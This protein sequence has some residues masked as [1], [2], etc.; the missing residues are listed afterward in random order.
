MA[1]LNCRIA[2]LIV[3]ICMTSASSPAPADAATAFDAAKSAILAKLKD[4]ES[5]KFGDMWVRGRD[6]C[7]TVNAK[8]QFGGYEGPK[9]FLFSQDLGRGFIDDG[10]SVSTDP[11][12]SI[13]R[14]HAQH[15][16]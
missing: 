6:I 4:P 16:R 11:L 1:N 14:G 3:A 2:I 8:N 15:C 10:G 9:G 13:A 12:D 7:G 5:A